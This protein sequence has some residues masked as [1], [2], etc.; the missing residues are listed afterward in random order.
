MCRYSYILFFLLASSGAHGFTSTNIP[1]KNLQRTNGFTSKTV[2]QKPSAR[3]HD[4]ALN[5]ILEAGIDPLTTTAIF[6]AAFFIL[7]AGQTEIVTT[8]DI[9]M[10]KETLEDLKN[11]EENTKI[12][13]A[14]EKPDLIDDSVKV[15]M[16]EMITS[17]Q[18]SPI[19]SRSTRPAAIAFD[20]DISS[21]KRRVASTLKS[22]MAMKERLGEEH[23][24]IMQEILMQEPGPQ[25]PIPKP[26][27]V[28]PILAAFLE[29]EEEIEEK[30]EKS[31]VMARIVKKLV[32][33]WKKFSTLS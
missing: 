13:E 23:E 14:L 22:E 15:V 7:S 33:P 28:E 4:V 20:P 6:A 25:K 18:N 31:P 8:E 26:K 30:V 21:L 2:T 3:T 24:E 32:M 29:E 16:E 19:Q 10:G 27:V 11:E 1:R 9:K 5:G 17:F 12:D